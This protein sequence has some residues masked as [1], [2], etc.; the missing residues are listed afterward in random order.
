MIW[1]TLI[2]VS[3]VLGLLNLAMFAMA[4]DRELRAACCRCW[5]LMRGVGLLFG[6]LWHMRRQRTD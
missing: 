2:G 4:F 5:N 3:L 6:Y 1:R